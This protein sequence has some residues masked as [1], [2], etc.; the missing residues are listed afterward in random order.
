MSTQ[1]DIVYQVGG[2]PED[3]FD[4]NDSVL[5]DP[6]ERQFVINKDGQKEDTDFRKIIDKVERLAEGIPHV[7]PNEITKEVISNYSNGCTTSDLDFLA[8][9][10]AINYPTHHQ[11]YKILAG[12]LFVDDLH[13]RTP[14][15][16]SLATKALFEW[17]T[18]SREYHDFVEEN[19]NELDSIVVNSLD[20]DFGFFSLCTWAQLYL[21]K[22]KGQ[23]IERPQYAY[24]R[25]A[26]GMCAPR[27]HSIEC[28]CFKCV[29]SRKRKKPGDGPVPIFTHGQ[30][31]RE[32]LAKIKK[33]YYELAISKRYVMASPTKFNIGTVCGQLSSCFTSQIKVG[34]CLTFSKIFRETAWT[35]SMTHS[36][37]MP[38]YLN[39]GVVLGITSRILELQDH[40]L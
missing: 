10:A 20:R 27:R 18:L 21:L 7:I 25:E 12:R 9:K 4:D 30:M 16:F 15:T 31:T 17:G 35:G 19:A 1:K 29:P 3:D 28:Q 22:A 34:L 8:M 38:R 6:G 26:V 5:E 2:L 39:Q 23:T 32:V 24:M 36:N 14:K 11:G 13:R 33:T 37:K 40:V